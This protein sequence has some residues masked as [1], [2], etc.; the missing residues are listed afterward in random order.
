MTSL[1]PEVHMSLYCSYGK[2]F[3][4]TTFG[5]EV[6]PSWGVDDVRRGTAK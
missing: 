1:V 2:E 3:F 5:N 6:D 4:L